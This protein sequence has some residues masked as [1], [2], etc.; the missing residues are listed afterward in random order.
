MNFLGDEARKSLRFIQ[1]TNKDKKVYIKVTAILMLDKVYSAGDIA[2]IL[3]V[4]ISTIYRFKDFFESAE[5]EK[6]LKNNYVAYQGKLDKDQLS[7]LKAAFSNNFYQ[8]SAEVGRYI[9][10]KFG[11]KMHETAVA[12]L[13]HR[14]GFGYKKMGTNPIKAI[15]KHSKSFWKSSM[16]CWK[17]PIMRSI[18]RMRFILDTIPGRKM[19]GS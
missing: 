17:Q 5:L 6:Y 1:S 19:V 18:L 12:K 10:N 15:K 2:E 13:L 8:V 3:G 9:G 11:I 16:N 14:L 4:D 7:E